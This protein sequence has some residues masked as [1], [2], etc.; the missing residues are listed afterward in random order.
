MFPVMFRSLWVHTISFVQH[1]TTFT[2]RVNLPLN[3]NIEKYELTNLTSF[4]NKSVSET[5]CL[6]YTHAPITP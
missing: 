5:L 1:F 3:S 6:S 2:G 4:S